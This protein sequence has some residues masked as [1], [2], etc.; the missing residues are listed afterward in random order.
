[1]GMLDDVTVR[2][3]ADDRKARK[4]IRGFGGF[5][6]KS[7]QQ[8]VTRTRHQAAAA[9]I[10]MAEEM[11]KH[12]R[13][14]IADLTKVMAGA[15]ALGGAASSAAQ[16]AGAVAPLATSIAAA[17]AALPAF[18]AG[19]A[20]AFGAAKVGAT[21]L[22]DALAGDE[23]ALE[24]LA[25]AGR[26]LVDVLGSLKPAWE[27]VTRSV[28]GAM[29]DGVAADLA[30]LAKTWMPLLE[31]GLT[32]VAG[33]WNAVAGETAQALSQTSVLQG[34]QAAVGSTA[35][36]LEAFAGGIEPLLSGVGDLIAG[37]SPL[38]VDAGEAAAGLAEQFG[39]W[40]AQARASGE[41][42]TMIDTLKTTLTIVGGLVANIGSILAS[43]FGAAA[44]TGGGLLGT[45]EQLTGQAAAFFASAEGQDVLASVFTALAAIGEG[46]AP[47]ILALASAFGESLA[48][49][50]GEI[51]L[52]VGPA[53][54]EVAD[55][56][57][58][59]LGSIDIGPLAGAFADL[60]VAVAPLLPHIG[61][62]IN[63]IFEVAAEFISFA[64]VFAPLLGPLGTLLDLIVMLKP[65]IIPL[66]IALGI[67]TVA[68]WA[69]N[70]AMLANPI[71]LIITAII[72]LIAII[73]WIATETTFFQDLWAVCWGSVKSA[74]AAVASWWTGTVVP[75]FEAAFAAI[76]SAATAAKDWIVG[77]FDSVVSFFSG[78][79]D[80]I[81]SAVSGMWDGIKEGFFAVINAVIGGWNDLSFS[82][83]SV[84]LGP[85]GS[86]GGFTLST[87]DI[88]ML[89]KG[90]I[91]TGP[92]LAMVGEGAHDEA[93]VPLP[94]GAR[95][96]AAGMSGGGGATDIV[97]HLDGDRELVALFRRAIKAR[98]GNVQTVLGG[99]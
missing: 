68:Q 53:L 7:M 91:V 45:L 86:V 96:F 87:P 67:W 58:T 35:L 19:A 80:R 25:P 93:V 56:L 59:A 18:A 38:L 39:A 54:A 32:R 48:P 94:K 41:F 22:S 46:L 72:A 81:S 29:L 88:P 28:Q 65:V 11:R 10:G 75:A 2:L 89:A 30:V 34:F 60:L 97:I 24:K 57:G 12:T 23:D 17:G 47:V 71:L 37:F 40:A 1:M 76:G 55:A 95:D 6:D 84:D 13:P 64:L 73:V 85:L 33:G 51:A 42:V 99:A 52:V 31:G 14:M 83:P 9:G 16:L 69:I 21:G 77:A 43:V 63:M 15:T 26:E 78:L 4:Q 44:Q 66:A 98:G 79:P 70:A 90:G 92:T 20:V 3:G 8:W 36:G 61:E 74:A 62:L 50:I 27:G 5:L 82:V 49:I